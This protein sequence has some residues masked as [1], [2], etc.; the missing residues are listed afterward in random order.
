M[1]IVK[2]QAVVQVHRV[3]HPL[4][5]LLVPLRVRVPG[6]EARGVLP[7]IIAIPPA[8]CPAVVLQAVE[9]AVE[10]VLLPIPRYALPANAQMWED[11]GAA[12]TI[13]VTN[14]A[15]VVRAEEQVLLVLQE[16]CLIVMI[17]VPVQPRGDIGVPPPVE[18]GARQPTIVVTLPME[19]VP[20]PLLGIVPPKL[21]A[22]MREEHGAIIIVPLAAVQAARA[23]HAQVP[24]QADARLQVPA[25]EW[26]IF[27]APLIVTVIPRK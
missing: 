17:L 15:A 21:I 19:D 26:V 18:I 13:C 16:M 4:I 5:I 10:R 3:V 11:I 23:H 6:P 2:V 27:G 8:V 14:P 22:R 25:R 1:S 7:R 24:I 9:E 20:A 12:H